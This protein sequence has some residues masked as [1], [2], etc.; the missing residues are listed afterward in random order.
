MKVLVM[1]DTH[2]NIRN[3]VEILNSIKPLGINTVIHCGDH[4]D[5][6][7]KLKKLYPD[8]DLYA[9]PGNCDFMAHGE[10]YTRIVHIE[11]VPILITHGHRHSIKWEDY[12]ELL[13]D[14]AAQGARL[15]ICGHSHAAYLKKEE[16][17]ILLNPGSITSPRD[18]NYPSYAVIDLENGIIKDVAIMQIIE[19]SRVCKHPAYN[20]YRKK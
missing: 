10:E 5:D 17:I 2:H 14:A 18:F 3:A 6:A 20:I 19:K 16:G 15:A 11:K 12:S 1:S 7:Y 4:I 8:I 9:V 13:I